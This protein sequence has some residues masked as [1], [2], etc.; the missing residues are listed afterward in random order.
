MVSTAGP[1]PQGGVAVPLYRWR[2]L[3][4][5]PRGHA[6]DRAGTAPD[7]HGL[8]RHPLIS[9]ESSTR[10]ESSLRR[11]FAGL[12]LEP[13]IALTA[14]DADLIKT[15]VRA[16]LGVGLLADGYQLTEVQ[17]QQILEMRLHR[18]TG[19]EQEKLTEEYKL[20]L[21]TIRGLIEILEDPDVLL[22][23]I[24]TELRNVK[25]EFGDARRSEIRASE[26]DLDILDLIEPEDVVVTVS[27]AGYAKR[28]PVSMVLCRL[29]PVAADLD[30]AG[31]WSA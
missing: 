18:L 28:Q 19:L 10:P 22:E 30:L 2:R 13:H 12:G 16:G 8:A 31:E 4:V 14:L 9:Y 29:V 20:L 1:T 5:V 27:Q 15:Y 6:L 7:M 26:E 21:E 3:V 24:R 11:A 23:V 25:E 17:A